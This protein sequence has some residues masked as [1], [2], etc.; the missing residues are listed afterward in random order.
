[1]VLFRAARAVFLPASLCTAY[2]VVCSAR[3]LWKGL[4][5]LLR[6]KLEVEVLDALSIGISMLRRDFSTAGS[7][8]FLLRLSELLEEWTREKVLG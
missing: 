5:C 6:R 4:R 2:T 1:M 3:F 8:M 7:V